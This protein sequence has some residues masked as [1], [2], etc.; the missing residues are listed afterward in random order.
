MSKM[1]TILINKSLFMKQYQKIKNDGHS[2]EE[3]I[4]RTKA[5]LDGLDMQT[6]TL[7]NT[8]NPKSGSLDTFAVLAFCV[9]FGIPVDD[10]SKLTDFRRKRNFLKLYNPIRAVNSESKICE[11]LNKY[12]HVPQGT[13]HDTASVK[14][15][16][17]NTTVAL[18]F[19]KAYGFD[20]DDIFRGEGSGKQKSP[21]QPVRNDAG[22]DPELPNGF[23]GRFY[24]YFFNS[25]PDYTRQ[26]KI[27]KFILDINSRKITMTLRQFGLKNKI[28][29][30]GNIIMWG[31]IIHN[32]DFLAIA[33]NSDDDSNFCTLA[34]KKLHLNVNG[35]LRFR[36][37]ALLIHSR[38]GDDIMPV[39]QS[40]IFTDRKIDL[41]SESNR[42]IL[43]GALA[44]TDGKI[45]LRKDDLDAFRD[46]V[47]IRKYF[48][49]EPPGQAIQE[50]V[51]VSERTLLDLSVRDQDEQDEL[52]K[53]LLQ[54]KAN[55]VSPRLFRFPNSG[56]DR[57]W[58]CVTALCEEESLWQD[59][60][61]SQEQ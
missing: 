29:A 34:Y 37:G 39:M 27:D 41:E 52:Y 53:I 7:K 9:A 50:Y 28:Y 58:R 5:Q 51:E 16:S 3:I 6:A 15:T 17:F 23:E 30:P 24:G 25:T 42:T 61:D 4:E 8:F 19:C 59:E 11:E 36:K 21:L 13:L 49:G 55:A 14:K 57:S 43:Q 20:I 48:G 60:G 56:E 47:T 40:F 45:W 54:M 33:F 35:R 18:A 31:K 26:G 32:G 44:L 12:C 22:P 46:A 10:S 1:P 38:G 2:D